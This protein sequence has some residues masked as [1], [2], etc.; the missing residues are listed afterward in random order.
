MPTLPSGLTLR[1]QTYWADFYFRG[2]R[3]RRTL[4]TQNLAEA[5]ERLSVLQSGLEAVADLATNG[6]PRESDKVVPIHRETSSG[7]SF[8]RL[9]GLYA[10]D[11]QLRTEKAKSLKSVRD[12][13]AAR[14]KAVPAIKKRPLGPADLRRFVQIRKR[15]GVS[16]STINS[17]LRNARAIVRFGIREKLMSDPEI[18]FRGFLQ[19]VTK[20]NR[21]M[22]GKEIQALF[23]A[24]DR[25]DPRAGPLLRFQYHSGVRVGELM[26]I[27]WGWLDLET[28]RV[29]IRETEDWSTK[30]RTTRTFFLPPDV[31][32]WLAK[33]K[34]SLDHNEDD[35]PLFQ[36]TPGKPWTEH[37]FKV[38]R[39]VFNEAGIDPKK[40]KTHALRHSSVTDMLESGVPINVVM[41]H[42]GHKD[43]TTTLRYAHAREESLR[44][45]AQLMTQRR[46]RHA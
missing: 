31:L 27:L 19:K 6:V 20:R 43:A 16:P 14:V 33:Y 26:H 22:T 36:M 29:E 40:G 38:V 17:A 5:L 45:A 15:D 28:G 24:A 10:A 1:G 21:Y 13:V 9:A 18:I 34:A 46:R 32:P 44:E 12:S 2:E 11:L 7:P 41:E 35:D 8:E 42:H 30:T 3:V 4:R 25:V 23:E 39:K 37:I